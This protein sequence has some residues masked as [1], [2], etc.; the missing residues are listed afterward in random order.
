[1]CV[2]VS[3]QNKTKQN[4]TKQNKTKQNKQNKQKRDKNVYFSLYLKRIQ[5]II[6]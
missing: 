2:C 1:V 4:K 6:A 5:L 3:Q